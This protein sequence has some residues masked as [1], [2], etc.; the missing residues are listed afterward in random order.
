MS[1]VRVS[2][3]HDPVTLVPAR[4]RT[5]RV[6]GVAAAVREQLNL[7]PHRLDL[8]LLQ[9][10]S[11]ACALTVNGLPL[12]IVWD[13]GSTVKDDAGQPAYGSSEAVADATV[14]IRL[15]V[16]IVGDEHIARSTAVHELGHA[17][18]DAP[19]WFSGAHDSPSRAPRQVFASSG[20]QKSRSRDWSEWRANEF[21]GSLLAPRQLL[22]GELLKLAPLHRVPLVPGRFSNE[23]PVALNCPELHSLVD[24]L[25]ETFGLSWSFIAVRLAKYDLV[26]RV[27][28]SRS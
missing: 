12:R 28:D 22:H 17:V 19:S 20:S 2:Y 13:L 9:L 5:S 24:A 25:G 14:L 23:P 21:M 18:F 11:R 8:E 6:A 16:Q 26:A 4:L 27:R 1:V 7:L 15:N 3:P 10:V